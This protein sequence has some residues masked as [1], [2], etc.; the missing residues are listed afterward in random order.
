MDVPA[1]NYLNA[2]SF[3][4]N[5]VLTITNDT[6]PDGRIDTVTLQKFSHGDKYVLFT[7]KGKLVLNGKNQFELVKAFG[8]NSMQW[9]AQKVKVNK[10][11]VMIFG[12]QKEQVVLTP[13]IE[14][15]FNEDG[16]LKESAKK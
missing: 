6:L 14:T 12:E 2:N 3:D 7:N 15:A 11:P 13:L 16:S 4:E 10:I 1:T 5:E 8:R 9:V